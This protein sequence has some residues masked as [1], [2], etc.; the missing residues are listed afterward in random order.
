MDFVRMLVFI[1]LSKWVG[2]CN[3]QS[4]KRESGGGAL[5]VRDENAWAT[6]S[7]AKESR[8]ESILVKFWS[9]LK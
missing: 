9:C 3:G 7:Y 1:E 5:I 4:R 2:F 8:L 6:I